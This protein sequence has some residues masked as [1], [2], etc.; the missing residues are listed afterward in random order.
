MKYEYQGSV[1]E[2]DFPYRTSDSYTIYDILEHG[3]VVSIPENIKG[4]GVTVFAH[5]E[6]G[7]G[8]HRNEEYILKGVKKLIVPSTMVRL[9]IY[10]YMFPDLQELVISEQN[11]KYSTDGKMLFSK[12]GSELILA[13]SAGMSE[14]P[15]LV[16]EHVT[17]VDINAFTETKCRS[18]EFANKNVKIKGEPFDFSRWY[19]DLIDNNKPVYVGNMLF[20]APDVDDLVVEPYVTRFHSRA[21]SKHIPRKMVTPVIPYGISEFTAMYGNSPQE[22][23]ITTPQKVSIL[24]LKEWAGIRSVTFL[25]NRYFMSEDGV[26]FSKDCKTLLLYPRGKTDKE[27]EIPEGVKRI[28]RGAFKEQYYLEKLSI[29]GSVVQI[30]Q[31]AFYGCKNLK[32]VVMADGISVI[33]DASVFRPHGVFEKCMSL[34]DVV[35]PRKLTHI[36]ARAFCECRSLRQITIPEGVKSIGEYAFYDTNMETVRLPKSLAYIADGALMTGNYKEALEVYSF[37]G[38]ARGLISAI[39]GVEKDTLKKTVNILWRP[40]KIHILKGNGSVLDD[41]YV[42]RSLK[43]SSGAFIDSA[44]N[45]PKFSYDEYYLI[46]AD[47]QDSEEKIRFAMDMLSK[48]GETAESEYEQYIRRCSS[49]IALRMV[50]QK[51][52]EGL[53]SFIKK[54]Y[55]S[56]SSMKNLLG[57]CNKADMTTASAYIL[58]FMNRRKKKGAAV[59]RL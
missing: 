14:D 33:A 49:R 55:V 28:E 52:E 3:D 58:Q 47:I 51:N 13:L 4:T 50:D 23:V 8:Y 2:V 57:K 37:E 48:G 40:A 10:N 31:E 25:N 42:P 15:L 41:I 46:F 26:V 35:L 43:H 56:D 53:I 39:E 54:G 18:I 29:P 1:F 17:E 5:R 36:G 19:T 7:W 16:P 22:L 12:D 59:I 32:S 9:A 38:S 44:W 20:R 30:N 27:Y 11:T 34:T 24:Q 21:F 6:N 45:R